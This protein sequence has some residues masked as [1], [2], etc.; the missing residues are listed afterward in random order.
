MKIAVIGAGISGLGAAMALK[1]DHDVTVFEKQSRLGGHA[2][3]AL[4]D[5]PLG[6]GRTKEI[7]VD[8]GFI[9]YNRKTYPNLCGF[10]DHLGVETEWSDMSLGFSIDGG[11]IEWAGDNLNKIFAQR[12]NL[13]RP[14]FIKMARE[15]L[16]F[17][18]EALGDF[19]TGMNGDLSIGDWLD[20]RGY[21]DEFKR[22]YLYPMAG[23]IWSTRSI[24][25]AVQWRTVTNGSR[26]YVEKVANELGERIKLN[27]ETV[28]V[29]GTGVVHFSDGS[30]EKFDEVILA[31]HSNEALA[32]R[33][34]ADGETK[35]LL[36]AIRYAPNKAYLHREQHRCS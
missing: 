31:T 33:S 25:G 26:Q 5:Y 9:V 23:A 13:I 16:K 27:A 6:D 21:S 17:N 7:A 8:T 34:D 12:R 18:D 36:S 20:T 22:W 30:S 11:R 35:D 29:E 32:L 24:G 3:T 10:F 14:S 19:H 4:V 2:N 28:S 15:V 1:G